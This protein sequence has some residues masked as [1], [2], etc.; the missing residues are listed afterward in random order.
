MKTHFCHIMKWY[1]DNEPEYVWKSFCWLSNY[2]KWSNSFKYVDCKK[3][4]KKARIDIN[5]LFKSF[6]KTH[7]D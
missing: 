1:D 7:E 5:A 4:L 6:N 2:E 3:C